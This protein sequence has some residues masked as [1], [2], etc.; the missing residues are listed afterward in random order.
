MS[1]RV[2]YF[3]PFNVPRYAILKIKSIRSRAKTPVDNGQNKKISRWTCS[4][5]TYRLE[6]RRL[7]QPDLRHVF[8]SHI[9]SL[10]LWTRI[11]TL[12]EFLQAVTSGICPGHRE[13]IT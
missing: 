2:P 7:D 4:L 5:D 3:V 10:S 8:V 12:A 9:A 1:S 13:Q 6:Y 11:L